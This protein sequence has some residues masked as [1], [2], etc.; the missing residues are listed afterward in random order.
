M[1]SQ[2][3][4]LGQVGTILSKPADKK[5]RERITHEVSSDSDKVTVKGFNNISARAEINCVHSA[6]LWCKNLPIQPLG[7]SPLRRSCRRSPTGKW[8]TVGEFIGYSLMQLYHAW[9]V[10]KP[11]VKPSWASSSELVAL[12][13]AKADMK[14]QRNQVSETVSEKICYFNL[15]HLTP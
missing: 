13:K 7:S 8:V 10:P 3:P 9:A 5:G 14:L 6:V 1:W 15:I 4:Y 11:V 12:L 2:M